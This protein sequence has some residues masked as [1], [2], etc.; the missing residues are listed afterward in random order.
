M[1]LWTMIGGGINEILRGSG[2]S[3][4]VENFILKN[5]SRKI[6]GQLVGDLEREFK[7]GNV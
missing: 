2:M 1:N 4:E 5:L 7:F 6:A 3:D